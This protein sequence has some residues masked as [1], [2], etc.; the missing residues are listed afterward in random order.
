VE[1]M[2][3]PHVVTLKGKRWVPPPSIVCEVA[4]EEKRMELGL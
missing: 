2:G 4:E 3:Y 1:P